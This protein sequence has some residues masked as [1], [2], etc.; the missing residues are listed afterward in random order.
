MGD[1]DPT[2]PLF[3]SRAEDPALVGAIE[4]F[5]EALAERIDHL[6]DAER[7]GDFGRVA[8]L[9]RALACESDEAG[10]EPLGELARAVCMSAL[11]EKT[12]EARAQLVVLTA[13]ARRARQGHTGA[14]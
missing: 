7:E 1:R 14:F 11:A 5:V 8:R 3:S 12:D 2:G 13:T 10:Y 4:D 9:A 6:Q